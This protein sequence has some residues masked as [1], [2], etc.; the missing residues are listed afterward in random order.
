MHLIFIVSILRTFTENVF[1]A[2]PNNIEL[3]LDKNGIEASIEVI[4][5]N[6]S[7]SR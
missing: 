5:S 7:I 2:T 4:A 1:A 3:N 6:A